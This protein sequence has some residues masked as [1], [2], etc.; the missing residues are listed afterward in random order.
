MGELVSS[1]CSLPAANTRQAS[2]EG[3]EGLYQEPDPADIQILDFKTPELQ[4]THVCWL[5]WPP[6]HPPPRHPPVWNVLL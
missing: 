5:E 6:T 2:A 4:E 1:F 3:E